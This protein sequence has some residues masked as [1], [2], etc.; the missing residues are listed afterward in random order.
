MHTRISCAVVYFFE[1]FANTRDPPKA[2]TCV[3]SRKITCPTVLRFRSV[4]MLMQLSM[5]VPT[6]SM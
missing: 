2:T 6:P 4:P 5:I 1:S 3:A